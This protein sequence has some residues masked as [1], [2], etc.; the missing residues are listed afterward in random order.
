MW[1][2]DFNRRF[3]D[4]KHEISNKYSGTTI[5]DKK[6]LSALSYTQNIYLYYVRAVFWYIEYIFHNAYFFGSIPFKRAFF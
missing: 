6:I 4:K 2:F 5:D 1:N 3:F